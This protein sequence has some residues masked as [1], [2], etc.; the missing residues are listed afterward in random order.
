VLARCRAWI[1][2][3]SPAFDVAQFE[4]DLAQRLVT[5]VTTDVV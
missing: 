2:E 3:Q 4:S 1:R 5:S